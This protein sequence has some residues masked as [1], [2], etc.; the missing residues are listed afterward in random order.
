MISCRYPRCKHIIYDNGSEFKLHF[1]ALC[2]TFGIKRKLTSVKNPQANAILEC[3]HQTIMGMV[4]TA[5]IDMADTVV[6]P[7]D[8][9][10]QFSKPLQAQL[11]LVGI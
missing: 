1:R 10:I 3:V 2:D 8:I 9:E 5:E 7:R 11:F 4:R 6:A